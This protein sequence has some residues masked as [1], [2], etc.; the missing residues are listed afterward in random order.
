MSEPTK[1]ERSKEYEAALKLKEAE[2]ARKQ[3]EAAHKEMQKKHSQ[4]KA[5]REMA[6]KERELKIQTLN[7]KINEYEAAMEKA[8]KTINNEATFSLLGKIFRWLFVFT[9]LTTIIMFF[10]G[11]GRDTITTLLIV[12]FV[13]LAISIGMES[14]PIR[15]KDTYHRNSRE[16]RRTR[17]ALL[18]LKSRH[19]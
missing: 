17:L 3:Q 14:T 16:A 18:E 11:F 1:E 4:A 19:K 8:Q 7:K 2:K 13:I 10:M 6:A 15:A 5:R 9:L 12:C